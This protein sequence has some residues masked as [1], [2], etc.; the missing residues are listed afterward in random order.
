MYEITLKQTMSATSNSD[1][2]TLIKQ[3]KSGD[4]AALRSLYRRYADRLFAHA[5]RVVGDP[6]TAE[7]VVQ[8]SLVAIWQGAKRYRAEGRV[9]A[10][11][12]SI[13]HHK[14]I[15]ALRKQPDQELPLLE[16]R[17]PDSSPQ[18]AENT[19]RQE[20]STALR[21]GLNQLSVEHRTVLELVFYQGMSLKET[22]QVCGCPVGTVK[23]RL[24]YAKEAL[25]GVLSREGLSAEDV[26]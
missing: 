5:L 21:E 7:D 18:P 16:D 4:Q 20:R 3:I 26:G 15:D 1:D 14:A 12:L 19:Q 23:S 6:A 17:L 25:R 2:S 8:E 10:W 22:A 9:I 11:M 24:S 13:V